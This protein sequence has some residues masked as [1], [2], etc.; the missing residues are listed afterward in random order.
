MF[1][2]PRD[3]IATRNVEEGSI[4]KIRLKSS[5]IQIDQELAGQLATVGSMVNL[6]YYPNRQYMLLASLDNT[7]F[8]TIHKVT[9]VLLKE[10]NQL[11]DKSIAVHELLIDNLIDAHDRDLEYSFKPELNIL[12]INL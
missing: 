8:S 1:I 5:H 2:P 11:G 10:R 4:G 6:V 9:P 3:F 7:S 12:K